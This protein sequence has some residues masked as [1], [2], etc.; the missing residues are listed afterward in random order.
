MAEHRR[1]KRKRA[2]VVIQVTNAITGE[3]LGRIGN[4]SADGMMLVANRPL[5]E[6]ALYQFRFAAHEYVGLVWYRL[7]Y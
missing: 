5:R 4:L 2:D 7:R 6:D 1:N 3:I